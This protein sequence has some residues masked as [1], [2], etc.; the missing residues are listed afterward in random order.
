MFETV[1]KTVRIN[2]TCPGDDIIYVNSVIDSYGNLGLLRT[3]DKKKC[4]CA[5][6][7]TEGTYK[8][9][10]EVLKALIEEGLPITE[11]TTEVTE[12]VDF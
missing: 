2:F 8:T 7:S 10:L 12:E 1:Q 9:V 6:F 3:V 5:V 4:N 11:I